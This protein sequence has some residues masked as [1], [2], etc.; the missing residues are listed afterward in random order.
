M[1]RRRLLLDE[2]GLSYLAVR[3]T[4]A[5]NSENL[6]LARAQAKARK[7]NLGCG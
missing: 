4:L 3:A 5:K 7:L 2:Q 6:D 1:D